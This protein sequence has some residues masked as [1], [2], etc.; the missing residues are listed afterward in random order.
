MHPTPSNIHKNRPLKHSA[1]RYAFQ[2]QEKDDEVKGSGNSYDFGARMYDS[3]LGRFLSIDPKTH[4]LVGFSPFNFGL[5]SP[6]QIIDTDGQFPIL[7]NGNTSTDAERAS[8]TYWDPCVLAAFSCYNYN[9]GKSFVGDSKGLSKFSGDFLFVD[10][11]RG[12]SSNQWGSNMSPENKRNGDATWPD[13]RRVA[14]M[15]TAKMDA[16]MIWDKLKESM[17]ED[18]LITEQI[19][20]VTHS[21]GSAYGN[22]Y[23]EELTR[24]IEYLSKKED[25]GFAYDTGL[26]IDLVVHLAP[27]QSNFIAVAQPHGSPKNR[28]TISVSHDGD[29]LADMDCTGDI[30]NISTTVDYSGF[31]SSHRN[32]TFETELNM[33]LQQHLKNSSTGAPKYYGYNLPNTNKKTMPFKNIVENGAY[34]AAKSSEKNK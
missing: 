13:D 14:G 8:P 15:N 9:M 20:V 32:S 25:I 1:Y 28:A 5:N 16:Q 11:N 12:F 2:A 26:V 3:R 6:I 7:I 30:C 4:M 22:G 19:Q 31:Q 21:R 10:G 17:N 18:G 34:S 33:I 29:W 27:H 23:I 24:Q